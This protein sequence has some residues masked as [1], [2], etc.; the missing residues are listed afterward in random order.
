MPTGTLNLLYG[1]GTAGPVETGLKINNKGVFSFAA[2]QTF[3]GSGTITGVTAGTG[4]S[5]GGT[6]GNL[7]LSLLKTC[8]THQVLQWNG[9]SWVCATLGGSITDVT[10]GT[11]LT[12]GGTSGNITLNLNLAALQTTNDAR[13]AQLGAANTFSRAQLIKG[14]TSGLSAFASDPAGL[15]VLG[16]ATT[17]GAGTGIGVEGLSE[18]TNGVGVLGS[19]DGSQGVGVQGFGFVGVSGASAAPSGTGV[20]GSSSAGLGVLE[21]G[22]TGVY[23]STTTGG[24]GVFG[25]DATNGQGVSGLSTSGVGVKGINGAGGYGVFAQAATVDS[26]RPGTGVYGE[27]FGTGSVRPGFGSDGVDGVA[28]NNNSGVAGIN[29]GSG[30][31]VYGR[32]SSANG[33]TGVFGTSTNGFGFQTDSN[34]SQTLSAGGWVKAMVFVD[35][36]TSRGTRIARCYN[37]QNPNSSVLFVALGCG[38]SV[39]H[40]RKGIDLIDF[41]FQINDRFI[42]ATGFAG[43]ITAC[44]LNSDNPCFADAVQPNANQ[45]L[46]ITADI[47]TSVNT[48]SPFWIIVF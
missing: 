31:G 24:V 15:G 20:S 39:T 19:G 25:H 14:T 21:T 32:N 27:T 48:D 46:T 4:L 5:G 40:V 47:Y 28:H 26:T 11:G 17:N 43:V 44:I 30:P 6:T 16:F 45:V 38:C 23:G 29:D 8:A 12:G 10:A 2:G 22:A 13:Y 42:S 33:G 35:P 1:S 41:G 37:S 36:F 34:V 9:T 18:T 3:P 7:T